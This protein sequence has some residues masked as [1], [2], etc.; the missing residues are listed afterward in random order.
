MDSSEKLN[1]D[2]TIPEEKIES[3]KIGDSKIDRNE[4]LFGLIIKII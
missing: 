1:P 2:Y 3:K 4:L